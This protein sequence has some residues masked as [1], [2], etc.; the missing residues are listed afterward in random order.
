MSGF[1]FSHDAEQRAT[2]VL[3]GQFAVKLTALE[4]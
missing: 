3:T 4:V 2:P 1:I